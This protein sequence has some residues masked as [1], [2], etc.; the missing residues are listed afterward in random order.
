M[1]RVIVLGGGIGGLVAARRLAHLGN[2]VTL[3]EREP[4]LGGLVASREVAG[5]RIDTGAESFATRKG[6]V[7]QLAIELGL[8]TDI[9]EPDPEGAWLRWDDDA[10]PLPK[11]GLLG[12]PGS[13]LADDV[14]RIV[15]WRGSLR[16]YCD[17]L[18][19]V[20]R[21][22]KET[23]LGDIVRRRM[24][25]L[26]LDRL[27]TPVVAGVHSADPSTVD[28]QA[29]A[30]GLTQNMTTQ[31]S[32]S[33][34]VMALREMAPAG[35][36]VQGIRGGMARLVDALVA[37]CEKYGVRIRTSREV[38]GVAADETGGWDV[39][40]AE[41]PTADAVRA[42][43]A[44]GDAAGGP[45]AGRAP[46]DART[47]ADGRT[48]ADART[49]ADASTAAEARTTADAPVTGEALHADAIVIATGFR[50]GLRLLGQT[51]VG[52]SGP[53]VPGP[54]AW[55][56]PSSVTIATL[57]LDDAR[58]DAHPRGTGVLVAPGTPGIGAKALT[59]SSAKWAWLAESLPAGRHV[60]RLSYGRREADD[61]V[62]P[63][64]PT[65]DQAGAL[66]DAGALLGLDLQPS[67]VV[68]FATTEWPASLAFATVG[69]KARVKQTL[70]AVAE[71][72]GLDVVGAWVSGTGLAA[73]VEHAITTASAL[74]AELR[75]A[76]RLDRD[77]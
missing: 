19:P 33:G 17:R 20:L 45:A 2:E 10:A 11:T 46:A 7:A 14:R 29:V 51:G 44:S 8:G 74:A 39:A 5:I 53:A 22:R 66:S 26:V 16:A 52:S 77:E 15:G 67:S 32:L 73:T 63:S 56:E 68:G 6:T 40:V 4:T 58:L 41:V 38:L 48:T 43:A 69:H 76:P 9:V 1:S 34:A 55:P 28:V 60:V 75:G 65:V 72:P 25:R 36:Q 71:V 42:D 47:A 64:D 35:S 57:V 24:G 13:P 62:T 18:L 70:R 21:V 50:A 54:S 59:H 61:L 31:G 27:V 12:I 23:D 49:A 30:P 37:D 3:I